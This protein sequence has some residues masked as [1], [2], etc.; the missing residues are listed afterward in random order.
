MGSWVSGFT[1]VCE[2]H[3]RGTTPKEYIRSDP[4]W[5]PQTP[6]RDLHD[7]LGR[8]GSSVLV[9][10]SCGARSSG[11]TRPGKLFVRSTAEFVKGKYVYYRCSGYYGK[12]DLPRF[13]E[14]QL[15]EK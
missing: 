1:P 6:V 7:L 12:C 11:S 14:E 2:Y 15:S 9:G 5:M 10:H 8:R 4:V 3:R 13:R